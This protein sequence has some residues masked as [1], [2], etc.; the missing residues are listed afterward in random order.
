MPVCRGSAREAAQAVRLRCAVVLM[1]MVVVMM[2]MMMMF[3]FIRV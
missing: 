1:M 2:M 3:V